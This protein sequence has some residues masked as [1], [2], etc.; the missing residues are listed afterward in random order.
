MT[1]KRTNQGNKKPWWRLNKNKGNKSG[2][3]GQKGK[4]QDTRELRGHEHPKEPERK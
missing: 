1:S 3:A 4:S 2:L